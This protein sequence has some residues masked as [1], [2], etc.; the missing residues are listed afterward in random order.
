MEAAEEAPIDEAY[1]QYAVGPGRSPAARDRSQPAPPLQSS[2]EVRSSVPSSK[3]GPRLRD[4]NGGWPPVMQTTDGPASNA[5]PVQASEIA[6][7]G[8]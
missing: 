6:G 5:E 4:R 1:Y 7:G 8:K 2:S 3:Y